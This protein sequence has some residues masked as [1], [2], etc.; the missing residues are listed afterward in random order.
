[1]DNLPP[2]LPIQAV[3]VW[4]ATRSIGACLEVFETGDDEEAAMRVKDFGL[5]TVAYVIAKH[6][7][8]GLLIV[9]DKVAKFEMRDPE[10]KMSKAEFAILNADS[11]IP[12][13]ALQILDTE[14]EMSGAEKGVP[15]TEW[16]KGKLAEFKIGCVRT[17]LKKQ[18]TPKNAYE[19]FDAARELL[20][21]LVDGNITAYTID[22]GVTAQ[23]IDA[24]DWQ[25]RVF[26]DEVRDGH[27]HVVATAPGHKPLRSIRFKKDDIVQKWPPEGGQKRGPKPGAFRLTF[28][29]GLTDARV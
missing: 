20:R 12:N 6:R 8:S 16:Y 26:R 24:M 15:D 1:M 17:T 25:G 19:F 23:K 13:A 9:E 27:Y 11:R 7:R 2:Y 10:F 29:F 5:A 18:C 4:I 28:Q 21:A 14:F 3:L 22:T